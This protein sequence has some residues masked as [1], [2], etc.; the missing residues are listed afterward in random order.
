M[1]LFWSLESENLAFAALWTY[2]GLRSCKALA[3]QNNVSLIL[4]V[5]WLID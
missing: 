5:D 3:Q 2:S 1:N 4:L